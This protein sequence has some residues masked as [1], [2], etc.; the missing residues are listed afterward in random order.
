MCE[1]VLTEPM[2]LCDDPVLGCIVHVASCLCTYIYLARR[3]CAA[4]SSSSSLEVIVECA[5]ESSLG[6]F[7]ALH[8]IDLFSYDTLRTLQTLYM[9]RAS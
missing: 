2:A 4:G 6:I 3:S 1:I 9:Y 7:A 8:K 5:R